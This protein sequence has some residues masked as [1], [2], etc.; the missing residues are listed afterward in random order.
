MTD[1][2]THRT[3]SHRPA[4]PEA[5]GRTNDTNKQKGKTAMKILFGCAYPQPAPV[6]PAPRLPKQTKRVQARVARSL[7]HQTKAYES[8]MTHL[9]NVT[10]TGSL[11]RW[12]RQEDADAIARLFLVSSDGLAA[13]IWNGMDES[14]R[15]L[16]EIGAA[17]YA[18]TG[19]A[20]SYE[21]C[22]VACRHGQVVGMAHAF[23]M[24]A[25]PDAEPETDPVLR[26]YAELEDP[27]S[28]YVSGLAVDEAHRGHGIGSDLMDHVESLAI[29]KGL[30]RISLICFERN[31]RAL[32]FYRR[33]GFVEIDRRPIVPHESLSYKDGDALLMVQDL[34]LVRAR[35]VL[36]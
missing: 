7:Q 14:G 2:G 24:N 25:D 20:F 35:S 33:R 31:T 3:R 5:P 1:H 36:G 8:F 19:T 11:I 26:P 34:S 4:G 30:S 9:A 32:A 22:L 13:Y 23:E 15:S 12:A 21:N 29:A 17:R 18:R 6:P 10:A 27:G 28:L 16:R